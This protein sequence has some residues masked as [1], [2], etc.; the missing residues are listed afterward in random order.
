MSSDTSTDRNNKATEF[1]KAANSL[2]KRR[3]SLVAITSFCKCSPRNLLFDRVF[4]SHALLLRSFSSIPPRGFVLSDN[5]DFYI[6]DHRHFFG[7]LVNIERLNLAR[8]ISMIDQESDDKGN[9]HLP[10]FSGKRS[11]EFLHLV[12]SGSGEYWM[13]HANH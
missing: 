2:I 9:A 1:C 6:A 5:L 10:P 11:T 13:P 12:C 4:H 8:A 7:L 3:L